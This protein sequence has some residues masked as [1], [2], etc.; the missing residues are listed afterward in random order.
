MDIAFGDRRNFGE[1]AYRTRSLW[2]VGLIAVNVSTW[3]LAA[4]LAW[5]VARRF[6][7]NAAQT[8]PTS[9]A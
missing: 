1:L 8:P 6:L 9:A 4:R 2:I 3:A 7:P 5:A